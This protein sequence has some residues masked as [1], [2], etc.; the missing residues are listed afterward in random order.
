[1]VKLFD[2][3]TRRIMID[4]I[5]KNLPQA[6]GETLKEELEEL[7]RFRK[8][9]EVTV[10]LNSDLLEVRKELA[11]LKR[12]T[13]NLWEREQALV[14]KEDDV[15]C[16]ERDFAMKQLQ[17]QLERE[18]E[19]VQFCKDIALG[20]VRNVEYRNEVFTSSNRQHMV[21]GYPQNCCESD[22]TTETKKAV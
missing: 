3:D 18:R 9:S 11:N 16:R 22:N 20:L 21:N 2:E 17:A 15:T 1:M 14:K 7:A 19:K 8:N 12:Q 4:S 6:V 10:K 13:D 5:Q